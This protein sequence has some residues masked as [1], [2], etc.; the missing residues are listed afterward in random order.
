[1]V[2]KKKKIVFLISAN[3]DLYATGWNAYR[4]LGIETSEEKI[5]KF[6]KSEVTETQT[7]RLFTGPWYTILLENKPA[8]DCQVF[9]FSA[10][11]HSDHSDQ[12]QS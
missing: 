12:S 10:P 9:D 1:M 7:K 2:K 11:T 5:S 8:T 6:S 3:G 4:Q